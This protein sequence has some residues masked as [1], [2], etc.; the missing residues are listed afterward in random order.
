M[1]KI[2]RTTFMAGSIASFIIGIA[3]IFLAL[4]RAAPESDAMAARQ[5]QAKWQ[6]QRT[7]DLVNRRPW[8][9]I[10]MPAD[11]PGTPLNGGMLFIGVAVLVGA[12]GF[13]IGAAR[14]GR[15]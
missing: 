8:N 14:I 2:R 7:Q 11:A 3:L 6:A 13:G 10:R 5:A 1:G 15:Y 12:A 4:P 9:G